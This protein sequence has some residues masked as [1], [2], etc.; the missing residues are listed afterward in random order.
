MGIVI[1]D[2]IQETV[3]PIL[4]L[5]GHKMLALYLMVTIL[6]F[7]SIS[8]K[9]KPA[10]YLIETKD[11]NNDKSYSGKDYTGKDYNFDRDYNKDYNGNKKGEDYWLCWEFC[12]L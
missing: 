7:G 3:K 11:G 2:Y 9:P 8:A 6:L 5:T 1:T 4:W 12:W 10:T